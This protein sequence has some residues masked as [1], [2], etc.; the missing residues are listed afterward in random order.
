[1]KLIVT[2]DGGCSR[3]PQVGQ[4]NAASAAELGAGWLSWRRPGRLRSEGKVSLKVPDTSRRTT[5]ITP[6][7]QEY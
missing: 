1:M 7:R 2:A 4:K 5:S 6:S 3:A